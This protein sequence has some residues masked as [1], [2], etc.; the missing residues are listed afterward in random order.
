MIYF[1]SIILLFRQNNNVKNRST[2]V[3]VLNVF[4]ITQ[5]DGVTEGALE[6]MSYKL[7]T[8]VICVSSNLLCTVLCKIRRYITLGRPQE[9]FQGGGGKPLGGPQKNL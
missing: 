3:T 7:H 6:L 4:K 5:K 8:L 1:Y 2:I 9:F